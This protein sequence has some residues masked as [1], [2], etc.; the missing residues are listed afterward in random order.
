MELVAPGRGWV[1]VHP[2]LLDEDG[3]ARQAAFGGGYHRFDPSWFTVGE[4]GDR[5]VPC[6]TAAA[7]RLFRKG[8]KHRSVDRH[9]LDLLDG[10][11]Q[12]RAR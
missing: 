2:L 12:G 4:L 10:L 3:S 9:D 11:E 1:D 5:P 6:V 7:Q 8:Y